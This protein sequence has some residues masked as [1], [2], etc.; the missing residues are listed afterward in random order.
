MEYLSSRATGAEVEPIGGFV[1]LYYFPE[2]PE[3]ARATG[4]LSGVVPKEQGGRRREPGRVHR[5]FASASRRL[6]SAPPARGVTL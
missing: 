6:A 2:K 3:P 1:L 5:G 4:Y